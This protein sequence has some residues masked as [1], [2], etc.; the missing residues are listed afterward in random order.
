MLQICEK[1]DHVHKRV[2]FISEVENDYKTNIQIAE[3]NSL[4]AAIAVIKF[5]KFYG[6][7]IDKTNEHNSVFNIDSNSLANDEIET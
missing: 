4:T 1:N 2:S 3:L 5:K 7:Y 6:F